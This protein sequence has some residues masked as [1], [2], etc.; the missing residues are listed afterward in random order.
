VDGSAGQV[1]HADCVRS[2]HLI[3]GEG[4]VG[5]SVACGDGFLCMD[6]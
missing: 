4:V 6:S 2:S 3:G 1:F 5:I